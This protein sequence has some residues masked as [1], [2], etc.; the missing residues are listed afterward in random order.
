[1]SQTLRLSLLTAVFTASVVV[2]GFGAEETGP[3]LP[4]PDGGADPRPPAAEEH[5][6]P[7]GAPT[8][9]AWSRL[10]RELADDTIPRNFEKLDGWGRQAEVFS[11]VRVREKNGLP[12][13]S[14]RTKRVNHG[15][16]RR[17]RIALLNPQEKVRFSI[18]DVQAG[19]KGG[20]EFQTVI[21]AR[22]RCT[23]ES[24]FWNYGL[25]TGSTMVQADATLRVVARF[26]VSGRETNPSEKGWLVEVEYLPEL[27]RLRV[28]LDDFD[29]RRIGHLRGDLAD[30]LGDTAQGLLAEILHSQEGKLSRRI[31]KE[32]AERDTRIQLTLP[33]ALWQSSAPDDSH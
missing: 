21:S 17:Y 4:L 3:R 1:M 18:R 28:E 19:E 24:E 26:T 22:L 2:G 31:R 13:L 30:G 9:F 7:T 5:S 12:R 16:W 33:R 15:V 11:G 6:P 23:A 8:P 32:L 20:L 10:L 29:V 25:R 14:K 27:D